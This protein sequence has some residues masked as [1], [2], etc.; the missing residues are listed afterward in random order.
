MCVDMIDKEALMT[1]TLTIPT[2]LV[3]KHAENILPGNGISITNINILAKMNSTDHFPIPYLPTCLLA[4]SQIG[5]F[6]ISLAL[7][8]NLQTTPKIPRYTCIKDLSR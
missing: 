3:Q 2:Q 6:K 7:F 8:C 4:G 1:V 5:G